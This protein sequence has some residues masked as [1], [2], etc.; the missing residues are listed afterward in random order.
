[1][2]HIGFELG[3]SQEPNTQVLGKRGINRLT[4][5]FLSPS[6]KLATVGVTGVKSPVIKHGYMVGSKLSEGARAFDKKNGWVF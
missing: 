3:L 4:F 2:I 5:L 1:M 6:L